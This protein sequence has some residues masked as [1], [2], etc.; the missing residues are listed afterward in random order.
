MDQV[1]MNLDSVN[2][3]FETLVNSRIV[4]ASSP[5]S[6]GKSACFIIDIDATTRIV[7]SA[8]AVWAAMGRGVGLDEA[9]ADLYAHVTRE[10][11]NGEVKGGLNRRIKL[12]DI[13][14]AD[15]CGEDKP[16]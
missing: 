8:M 9:L 3:D 2:P 10:V 1:L 12:S 15:M 13:G 11:A 5:F 6:E 4:L 16:S 14:L 7:K